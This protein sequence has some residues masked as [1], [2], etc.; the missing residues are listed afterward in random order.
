MKKKYY[1]GG[2]DYFDHDNI[3]CRYNLND[4]GDIY[5]IMA[6]SIKDLVIKYNKQ[7]K[8]IKEYYNGK[9]NKRIIKNCQEHHLYEVVEKIIESNFKMVE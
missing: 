1:Y 8:E 3:V 9:V 2:L 4:D 5:F 6:W 7:L